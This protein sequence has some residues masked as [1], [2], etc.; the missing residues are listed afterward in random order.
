M[1]AVFKKRT[2]INELRELNTNFTNTVLFPKGTFWQKE[3]RFNLS[4]FV[5]FEVQTIHKLNQ[6]FQL[7]DISPLFESEITIAFL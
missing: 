3:G 2:R 1:K 5:Q 6:P 7:C 4:P